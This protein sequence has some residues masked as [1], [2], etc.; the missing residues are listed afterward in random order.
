VYEIIITDAMGTDTLPPLEIPLTVTQIE[1]ATDVTTLDYNVYTDFVALK[2][3]V[4][5]TWA[6][7]SEEDFLIVK[8]YYERQFTLFQY[9]RIT[10]TELGISDRVVRM[11]LNPRNIIDHC[12]TVSDV[13]VSFRESKQNPES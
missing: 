9:P 13:T 6:F 4:S 12:G 1:G 11:S 7:L 2:S 5:H 10:I 3:L 8:G